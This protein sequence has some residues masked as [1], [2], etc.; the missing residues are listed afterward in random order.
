MS[1][2]GG[3]LQLLDRFRHRVV[4]GDL[5]SAMRWARW[6]IASLIVVLIVG[7]AAVGWFAVVPQVTGDV[8]SKV[9]QL[10]KAK[11][12]LQLAVVSTGVA[13]LSLLNYSYQEYRLQREARKQLIMSMLDR[14]RTN[15]TAVKRSRRLLRASGLSDAYFATNPAQPDDPRRKSYD[16]QMRLLDDAQLEFENLKTEVAA[17]R[18]N[19][20]RANDIETQLDNLESY[21]GELVSEWETSSS[22]LANGKK[23]CELE[24][25]KGLVKRA[26]E[27]PSVEAGTITPR[28]SSYFKV[29]FTPQ[30]NELQKLLIQ[31]LVEGKSNSRR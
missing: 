15:Y 13:L 21:L 9:L 1:V 29:G 7:I 18:G 5:G 31:Q 28:R 26:S 20:R 4:K 10:E 3:F 2:A 25:L 22:D 14:A 8:E 17:S 19:Y 16:K 24:R 30:F 12:V 23:F 27:D 11:A 6:V